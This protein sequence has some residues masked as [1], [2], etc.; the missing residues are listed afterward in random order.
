MK[1]LFEKIC[2]E[3]SA[4]ARV[5]LTNP[6]RKKLKDDEKWFYITHSLHR[7]GGKKVTKRCVVC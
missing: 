6:N 3:A 5:Q 4:Y 2:D 1:P 7:E